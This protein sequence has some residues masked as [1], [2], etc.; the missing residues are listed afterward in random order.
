MREGCQAKRILRFV[1]VD[2]G[3]AIAKKRQGK[4][5]RNRN[6]S[7]TVLLWLWQTTEAILST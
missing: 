4:P 6:Q 1:D 7:A 2:A 3:F 5:L